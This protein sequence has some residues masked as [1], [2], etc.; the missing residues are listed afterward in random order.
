M[1]EKDQFCYQLRI[2]Y[3]RLN[4][5]AQTLLDRKLNETATVG[6]IQFNSS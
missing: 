5:F 2:N 6:L 4:L 1:S 3:L